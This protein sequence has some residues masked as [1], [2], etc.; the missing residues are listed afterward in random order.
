MLIV[1]FT[2]LN[3]KNE[4]C[5]TA[6]I[7]LWLQTKIQPDEIDKIISAEIPNKDRDPILYEIVF[8]NMIHGRELNIRSPCMNNGKC[9]KKYPRKLVKDTQTGD[10]GYPTYRRRSPDDGGYT[11]IL[12]VR[13]K[14][15]IVVDNRWVVPYCPGL[16]RCFN[17]HINVEYCHSVK[18]IKYICK[19]INKGSDRATFSVDRENDEVRNY[20]NGRYICTSEAF[21]R[22]YNFEIHDRDPIVKHLA[23]HLE[24]GQR[25]FFNANNLHQVIKNPRKTSLTAFFECFHLRLLL[26]YVQGLTSF[27]SLKAIDG[28]IHAT[29]KTACFSLGLLENDEQWNNALAVATVS[30]SSSKLRELFAII[31][32]FCPPSEPQSLWEQFRNDFCEDILHTERTRLNDLQFTFSDEIF[33]RGLIEIEDKVVC[34]SKKYLI[35]FGMKSPVRNENTSDPFE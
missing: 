15:E 12:K 6:T 2:V 19:Y 9:S 31:I 22:I 23:V 26:N 29:F 28:V 21:W 1:M 33:N 7:L 30:K 24:N 5:H 4:V 14:K 27:E 13:G 10:D 25:V 35:E 3:G 16:P 18:A 20:L 8:K 32:V 17:A 34:L 11:A